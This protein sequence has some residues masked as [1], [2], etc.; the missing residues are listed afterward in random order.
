M[1]ALY[2]KQNQLNDCLILNTHERICDA[3]IANVFWVNGQCIY[4]P[5]LDEGCIAGVMRKHLL[6]ILPP[7]GYAIEEK[8]FSVEEFTKADEL[9]LT[10]AI[11]G[12]RWVKEFRERQ[13]AN[14]VVKQVAALIF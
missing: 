10:N 1:G 4:T 7:N 5:P 3:T 13:F 6:S 9:F 2:A 12:I 11:S 14:D 8:M